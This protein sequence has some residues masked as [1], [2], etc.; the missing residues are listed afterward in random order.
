[1]IGETMKDF[2]L[3]RIE[4]K[5]GKEDDN[6]VYSILKKLYDGRINFGIVEEGFKGLFIWKSQVYVE[7]G[8]HIAVYEITE[9]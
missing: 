5:H 3:T 2:P 4:I 1:M 7:D 9:Y 6:V 8:V